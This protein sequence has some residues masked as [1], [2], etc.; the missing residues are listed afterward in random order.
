MKH[1]TMAGW[2]VLMAA[3]AAAQAGPAKPQEWRPPVPAQKVTTFLM[4]EGKAEEAMTF[5]TS[6]FKQSKITNILRYG[7]E[8]PGAEGSVKHATFTLNGQ[9]Y[10]AT[11]SPVKHGFTFTASMSLYVK[12]DSEKEIEELFKKLSDKG[13]VFM[14]LDKYPFSEKFGW[15]ADRFG[16]SWQL[17]LAK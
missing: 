6:L 14:P 8:G 10:M 1:V 5:Y 2:A 12:C 4:F 13:Q 7:K 15:L 17:T 16:V 11:D 9:E 3:V